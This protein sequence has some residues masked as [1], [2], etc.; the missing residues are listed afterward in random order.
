MKKC[1]MYIVHPKISKSRNIL[2]FIVAYSVT[3][4]NTVYAI[5]QFLFYFNNI[6]LQF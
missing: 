3:L 2:Y 1:N 6:L 5:P 4:E